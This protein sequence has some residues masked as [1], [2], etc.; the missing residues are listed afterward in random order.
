MKSTA[1]I[2]KNITLQS[3]L[4]GI[5][6]FF[7]TFPWVSFG[8]N[9][10]DTQPWFIILGV[11][12]II[13]TP[14]LSIKKNVLF[15]LFIPIALVF[16]LMFTEVKPDFTLARAVVSYMAFVVVFVGFFIYMSRFCFPLK[17][18]VLSNIIWLVGAVLQVVYGK[19]IFE[20]LLLARTTE[21]R[22][23][24][25]F[26][27]EP[28]YFGLFLFFVS[29]MYLIS[30]EYRMHLWLWGLVLLNMVFIVFFS[31]SSMALLFVAIS[32]CFFII[33]ANSLRYFLRIVFVFLALAF[34][35]GYFV[36]LMPDTRLFSLYQRLVSLNLMEFVYMDASVNQRLADVVF[37]IHG[38]FVNWGL[39]GGFYSYPEMYSNLVNV[40]DGFFWYGSGGVKIMSFLG[41]FVYELGFFAVLFFA[42]LISIISDGTRKRYVE[43]V[44][45]FVLLN[46]AIP[47]AFPMVAMIFSMLLFFKQS[48]SLR[49]GVSG[50]GFP[51]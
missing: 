44:L 21:S 41:A 2:S 34:L 28:T 30:K 17:I 29:W 13:S 3:V 25:S 42:G 5:F 4:G 9:N 15:V 31:Q 18:I 40:Y 24:T 47:V 11:L 48:K 43:L 35:T 22:G 32:L 10:M 45:L 1:S 49:Q 19:M 14:K 51:Y 26:A 7:S 37:S 36:S 38:F 12:F 46:S 50:R 8:T 27:T 16:T 39:P 33:G 6:V 20:F 23:V